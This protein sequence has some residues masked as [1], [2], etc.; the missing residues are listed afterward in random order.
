[1]VHS[2]LGGPDGLLPSICQYN[3]QQDLPIKYSPQATAYP[4]LYHEQF[5]LRSLMSAP[6]K[7]PLLIALEL[8]SL[9]QI[10]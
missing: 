4:I 8:L 9:L 1:M 7:D 3:S 5:S 10:A 2:I 6:P